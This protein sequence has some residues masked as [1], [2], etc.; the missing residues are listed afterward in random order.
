[1]R[2][3]LDHLTVGDCD[4][5]QLAMAARA[6]NCDAICLFLHSMAVLPLMPCFDLTKDRTQRRE[7]RRC[8][9]ELGLSLDL[10]YPFTLHGRSEAADLRPALECAAELGATLV[11]VLSYDRDPSRQAERLAAFCDATRSFGLGVALEF[12]PLSQVRS[13][14]EAL[15]V[16]GSIGCP[17][18]V[19]VNVD[20]L[21]L[22]RSGG[23]NAELA[24]VPEGSIVYAQF[25]DGPARCEQS[26]MAREAS[27][28]RML[29]GGGAFDLA[30]FARALPPGCRASV[31]I[32]RDAEARAGVPINERA[33]EAVE[34]VRAALA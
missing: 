28:D 15:D 17:A 33:V 4:P 2:L 18:G 25:A 27:S 34:S 23:T 11:N 22:V 32:P 1:M 21:H 8:M 12:Y 31:E 9:D 30:A 5:L 24:S 3:A 14:A 26:D 19:G 29:G 13:L 20:L 6:A 16:V 7:L 10:A